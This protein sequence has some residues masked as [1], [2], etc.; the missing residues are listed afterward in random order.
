MKVFFAADLHGQDKVYQQLNSY[1][2]IERPEALILGGD[3]FPE[4]KDVKDTPQQQITFIKKKFTPLLELLRE[5]GI[6]EVL[7]ILGNHDLALCEN[8]ISELEKRGL[9][10]YIHNREFKISGNLSFI[11]YAFSPP[12]P[13]FLRDFDK[14][15]TPQSKVDKLCL[16]PDNTGY[17]SNGDGLK[18]VNNSEYFEINGSIQQDMEEL[19]TKITAGR[20]VFVCHAPPAGEFLGAEKAD[21]HVGSVAVRDFIR[22]T[23]PVI[24]LH[25]HIHFSPK[26]TGRFME[27]IDGAP[28][29][30]PGQNFNQLHGVFFDTDNPLETLRHTVLK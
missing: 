28:C 23:R 20:F 18:S 15:D 12:S 21:L 25:G 30:N 26:N 29:V 2:E 19:K 7:V 17:I 27:L 1:V 16:L 10:R 24:S 5:K 3:L 8:P 22:K 9:C 13:Y 6:K 11:G 4:A 14:K